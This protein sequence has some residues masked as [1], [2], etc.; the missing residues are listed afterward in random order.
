MTAIEALHIRL[1]G[2][3]ASFRHPLAITGTQISTPVPSYSNLLG[4]ISAC[5]GRFVRP[6]ETRV[7][8]EF[9]CETHFLELERTVRLQMDKMGRLHPHRKGQGLSYRQVYGSPTLNLYLTNLDFLRAFQ[10]PAATPCFG[11]SQDIAWISRVDRISLVP[12]SKGALGPTLLP[13]PQ[14]GI[15]GVIVRLPEWFNHG[16]QG[17]ARRP[18]PF[19]HYQALPS[20]AR[21][22]RFIVE[23][24]NL[25]QPSD[26]AQAGDA[27]YL[28]QWPSNDD[29]AAS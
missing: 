23:R 29:Q 4:I 6:S 15:A 28:H 1:E 27:V 5:E 14:S 18:G 20:I 16:K 22:L 25:F 24:S 21:G 26:A 3:T 13:Y 8:F 10:R 12:V 11:R 17:E 19:G 2:L 7:A 9:S